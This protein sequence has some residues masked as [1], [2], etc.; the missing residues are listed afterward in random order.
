MIRPPPRSPL[1]PYTTLFRPP[2]PPA[3]WDHDRPARTLP[4]PPRPDPSP[5]SPKPAPDHFGLVAFPR[6]AWQPQRRS[7]TARRQHSRP[8]H[9]PQH[10]LPPFVPLIALPKTAIPRVANPF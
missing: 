9:C 8:S 3:P 5:P 7:T 6:P 4:H 1:F 2:P 10:A